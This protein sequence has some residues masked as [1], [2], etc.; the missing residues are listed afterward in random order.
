MA[1][2]E[3][4]QNDIV[5]FVTGLQKLEDIDVDELVQEMQK[6]SVK[7]PVT[8]KKCKQYTA[9]WV[10]LAQ[11]ID[12]VF[13][14]NLFQGAIDSGH[15]TKGGNPKRAGNPS[16]KSSESDT[17]STKRA[18][19]EVDPNAGQFKY[20]GKMIKVTGNMETV[21]EV[22]QELKEQGK[23]KIIDNKKPKLV[24]DKKTKV[25]QESTWKHSKKGKFEIPAGDYYIG[26]MAPI[27]EANELDLAEGYFNKDKLN[28]VVF[29]FDDAVDFKLD[30]DEDEDFILNTKAGY[31]GLASYVLAKAAGVKDLGEYIYPLEKTMVKKVKDHVTCISGVNEFDIVKVEPK[32]SKRNDVESVKTKKV[33]DE[34]PKKKGK[35]VVSSDDEDTQAESPKKTKIMTLDELPNYEDPKDEESEDSNFELDL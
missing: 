21:V 29:K 2:A 35:K 7:N 10:S 11:A 23:I 5:K 26:D 1:V 31:I 34:T 24:K 6:E 17:S 12:Q 18:K 25:A 30:G 27:L 19:K 4:R 9:T 3:K 28:I 20:A 8:H 13:K 32:V 14:Q 16:S 15:L 33:D 22:L